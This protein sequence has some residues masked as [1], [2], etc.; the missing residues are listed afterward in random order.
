MLVETWRFFTPEFNTVLIDVINY[1]S[2][3][4]ARVDIVDKVKRQ[5]D[6]HYFKWSEHFLPLH[7]Q[8]LCVS[9]SYLL[10]SG[11]LREK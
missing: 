8:C 10:N 9:Q 4:H 5:L 7:R 3:I 1:S 6:T 11:D 2:H